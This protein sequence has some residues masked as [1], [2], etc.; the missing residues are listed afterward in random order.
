MVR[1]HIRLRLPEPAA[2]PSDLVQLQEMFGG[3]AIVAKATGLCVK[4]NFLSESPRVID[5]VSEYAAI[6]GIVDVAVGVP[7]TFA[8]GLDER[9]PVSA[10][11]HFAIRQAE[12]FTPAVLPAG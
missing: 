4:G 11:C 9:G 12:F 3:V 7:A 10:G 8:T 2:I 6:V 1:P 5:K